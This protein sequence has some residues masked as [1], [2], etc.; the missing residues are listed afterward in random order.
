MATHPKRPP[1]TV[2][3]VGAGPGDPE[4]VTLRAVECLRQADV[5]LYDYLVNPE[6]LVHAA[7]EA[8]RICLGRH[9]QGRIWTQ[10]EIHQQM[11]DA[12]QAGRTV[13]RLKGG[14]PAVFARATEEIEALESA[15]IPLEIVPG[16][17][18]ALAASS[19]AGIPVTHRQ[20]ASAV[21]LV[22]GHEESGKPSSRVDYAALA[23]FPGTLVIY[24]GVT[25]APD[26]TSELLKAGKS[27]D[28]PVAIIRRCSWPDQIIVRCQLS[29]LAELLQTPRKLR[30]P[31]IVIIGEVAQ[32]P[33]A[34]SWFEERP[35][36]GQ[37][38]LIT[39][40]ADQATPL[41]QRLTS[42]GANVFV[43]PAIAIHPPDDWDEVD[44]VIERLCDFDWL[45]FSSANGVRFFLQRLSDLGHDL[46]RLGHT[47]LA[48]I[49][50]STAN[51]L[52][53]FHLRCDLIPDEYRAEA[54][55]ES[56]SKEVSDKRVL[57]LRASRGREVLA[58]R[59]QQVAAEVK[60]VVVY[61]STDL[62]TPDRQIADHIA[63]G[64]FDWVTVTSSA[65]ARSLVALFGEDL[66]KARLASI[67][68]V[69]SNTLRELHI[70]PTA[71]A[72]DYTIDGMVK[73]ILQ[74]E[75]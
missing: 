48:C 44:K 57:L 27:P 19:F 65:I 20:L 75:D 69:T 52:R 25:T 53:R 26:W 66:Q 47:Q 74:A 4:L 51:E 3:L 58:E 9:G 36:F 2:Y 61:C 15:G 7:G 10:T 60:Q 28:T 32:L 30:P 34:T 55:A 21:A 72:A 73:A 11:I 22:T 59:L 68:P 45:V 18:A 42:L 13:V 16:I 67:S 5:I 38:I 63:A 46:R 71:E 6:I 70:E 49:G 37:R 35:L 17:T 29:E 41:R 39:R 54:L 1:G 23:K 31:I 56:L 33:S 40:P 14:D 64:R 12:A 62:E 8:E 43:Q 24:M 50:P